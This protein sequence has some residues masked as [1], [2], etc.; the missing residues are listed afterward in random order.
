MVPLTQ[1][2]RVRHVSVSMFTYFNCFIY[3]V[4]VGLSDLIKRNTFQ[5]GQDKTRTFFF[6]ISFW[7]SLIQSIYR[8]SCLL[9]QDSC[10][11]CR[12]KKVPTVQSHSLLEAFQIEHIIKKNS[13]A[14]ESDPTLREIFNEPRGMSFRKVTTM[15]DKLVSFMLLCT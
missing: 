11:L 3:Q 10:Q 12:L 15:K 8:S 9:A 6:L 4:T 13:N 5:L 7:E 14:V 1:Q 2:L